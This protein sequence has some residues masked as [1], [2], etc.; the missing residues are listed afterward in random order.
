MN[1]SSDS[2]DSIAATDGAG[3]RDGSDELN[4]R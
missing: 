2:T 4:Q 3:N 1:R